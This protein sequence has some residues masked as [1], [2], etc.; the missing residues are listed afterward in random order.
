MDE[1]AK[2]IGGSK[3]TIYRRYTS[4]EDLLFAV[5]DR[6][7]DR[8]AALTRGNTSGPQSSVE[9]LREIACRF[10]DYIMAPRIAAFTLFLKAEA[11]HRPVLRDRFVAWN[12]TI[13]EPFLQLIQRAQ[14]ADLVRTDIDG[15]VL[16]TILRDLLSGEAERLAMTWR[17]N[18]HSL[19]GTFDLRWKVFLT[20]ASASETPGA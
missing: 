4:K 11:T 7:L 15:R 6:D 3:L 5:V 18:D 8:L 2:S 17:A 1:I 16:V 19:A 14:N 13:D 20:F 9:L 12:A 10:Y